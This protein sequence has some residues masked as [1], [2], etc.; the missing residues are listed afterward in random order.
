MC[1]SIVKGRR[2]ATKPCPPGSLEINPPD[3]TQ[4]LEPQTS[5]WPSIP[6]IATRPHRPGPANQIQA[7]EPTSQEPAILPI[8]TRLKPETGTS[9]SRHGTI[10]PPSDY[11]SLRMLVNRWERLPIGGEWLSSAE[12]DYQAVGV[13]HGTDSQIGRSVCQRFALYSGAI[14]GI[15]DRRHAHDNTSTITLLSCYPGPPHTFGLDP[16]HSFHRMHTPIY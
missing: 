6:T 11:Q 14:P 13:F 3:Q 15:L 7:P 10:I 4:A 5:R 9:P 2:P 12:T 8:A 1:I 16:A